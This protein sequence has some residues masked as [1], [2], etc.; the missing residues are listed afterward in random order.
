MAALPGGTPAIAEAIVAQRQRRRL[1]TPEDLL[2]LGIVSAT[3]FYGTAAEGGFG[4]YLT[5]WGSGKININTAPKP[6]LAALPGMTPAM[7]EAIVRYRQGED[8]EPGTAD[9]RQ[10]REVA[11]LRTLDAIDRAALDPFE[12]LITV[13]PTAFRVIATGRV[14]SGQGVTSIHR[15]LVIIDRASRPTRIQH[16]RRLS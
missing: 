11:D 3:T 4:Q 1:A 12:A 9:D 15:R 13:V 14:V 8:Q 7:A 16:W 5:V 10:F 2:A 6:V